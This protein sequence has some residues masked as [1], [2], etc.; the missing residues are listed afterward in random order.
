[1]VLACS[2]PYSSGVVDKISTV[3]ILQHVLKFGLSL[4]SPVAGFVIS[5]LPMAM[6]PQFSGTVYYFVRRC[7][8]NGP[9]YIVLITYLD[10]V[11]IVLP[12]FPCRECEI[13]T[14]TL[15]QLSASQHL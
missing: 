6:A 1:M 12:F 11:C 5:V 4:S 9:L 3:E 10:P 15:F 2:E 13:I 14:Y 7:T 8:D